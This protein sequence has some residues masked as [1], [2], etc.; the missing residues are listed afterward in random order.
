MQKSMAEPAPIYVSRGEADLLMRLATC[1]GGVS[2]LVNPPASR[3]VN[4]LVSKGLALQREGEL[5]IT[6]V[7]RQRCTTIY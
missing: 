3:A 4:A 7:G 5:F 1:R 2:L 6:E